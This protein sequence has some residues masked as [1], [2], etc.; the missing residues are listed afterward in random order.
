MLFMGTVFCR[1]KEGIGSVTVLAEQPGLILSPVQLH[2][3]W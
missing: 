1:L 2:L 3:C